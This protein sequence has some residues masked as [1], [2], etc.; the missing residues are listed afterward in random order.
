MM[1]GHWNNQPKE[2]VQICSI[3]TLRS[4]SLYPEFDILVLDEAHFATSATYRNF[5][6]HYPNAY[7][8]PVTATPYVESSLRHVADVIVKPISF[9]ELVDQGYL[10]PPQ[11]FAPSTVDVSSC[12]V[13]SSTKDYVTKDL[14]EVL[15]ENAIVGNLVQTWREF[16]QDRPTLIFAA[17]IKHSLYIAER[18]IMAGIPTVHCD[19]DSTDAE[20]DEAIAAL[21]SGKIKC[22]TNVGIFCTGV[23][24]PSLS[25]IMMARP[26]KSYNLYIQQAGRGTRVVDGKHNFLLL[27]NAGNILRHGFI[28]KE[29]AVD[30]DGKPKKERYPG[31]KI[32]DQCYG[33]YEI[34]LKTCP[35]CGYEKPQEETKGRQIHEVNGTLKRVDLNDPEHEFERL[36]RVRKEMNFKR[37]WIYYQMKSKFGEDV[38]E[39]YCPQRKI[40]DWV[41]EKYVKKTY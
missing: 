41:R 38:A 23:D 17:S 36:K 34:H 7:L 12:K 8:L 20:R 11:Y 26:T 10:V 31:V 27:D 19:A 22:I 13:S 37:G 16:A 29:P 14:E 28:E 32:C 21:E 1:A 40:P 9:Q 33:A 3:D 2:A 30:L 39:T 5:L 25:C 6:S 24:I 4:R 35:H 15:M 18:F